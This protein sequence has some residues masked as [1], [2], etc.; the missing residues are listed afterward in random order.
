MSIELNE[1]LAAA[2]LSAARELAAFK[3]KA[4]TDLSALKAQYELEIAAIKSN[5][6]AELARAK[7]R[8]ESRRNAFELREAKRVAMAS[9][10][11]VAINEDEIVVEDDL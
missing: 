1:A 5:G 8:V 6:E 11:T 4:A 9:L 10:E 7:E 3:K 2:Q